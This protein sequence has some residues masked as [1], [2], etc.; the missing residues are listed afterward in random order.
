MNKILNNINKNEEF[1]ILYNVQNKNTIQDFK[2]LNSNISKL[3]KKPFQ[4]NVILDIIYNN[5]RIS[6]NSLKHI[7]EIHKILKNIYSNKEILEKV[8]H[9][10][11]VYIYKKSVI[12]KNYDKESDFKMKLS[13]EDKFNKDE[14]FRYLKENIKKTENIILLFRYKERLS[15]S[16]HENKKYTIKLDMSI[17]K[18]SNIFS[19]LLNQKENFEIELE[20]FSIVNNN[21]I[22]QKKFIKF[23]DF[24]LQILLKN[25]V[26]FKKY[27]ELLQT[28]DFYTM[29][30]ISLDKHIYET[31]IPY[32]Y[33]ITDKA[34]GDKIQLFIHEKKIYLISTNKEITELGKVSVSDNYI[35]EGEKI[36][37]RILLYDILYYKDKDVRKNN[38]KER[39][40]CLDSFLSL[41]NK[42]KNFK[43]DFNDLDKNINDYIQFITKNNNIID[44]KYI[45]L[46]TGLEGKNEVYMYAE[47]IWNA[48]QSMPY[49][50]DGIIF[51]NINQVY[52]KSFKL[53]KDPI[54]KWKPIELN[55]IDFY[56]IFDKNKIVEIEKQNYQMIFLYNY[57]HKGIVPFKKK[58]NLHIGYIKCD[59]DNILK[60]DENKIVKSKTIVEMIYI[61]DNIWKILRTR[62]DKTKKMIMT[63]SKYGNHITVAE[64]IF[65]IIKNPFDLVSSTN[66][67]S[68]IY[69]EKVSS[70]GKEM[71]NFNNHVK[72]YLIKNYCNKK[73]VLDVG[74]GKGGDIHKYF[75][76]KVK[77]IVG[78]EPS[79]YDLF[80]R[81]DSAVN[82]YKKLKETNKDVP[83]M[84]FIQSDFGLPLSVSKQKSIDK[85]NNDNHAN[86]KE[87]LKIT[88]KYNIINFSFSFHYLYTNNYKE[89]LFKNINDKLSKKGLVI[90]TVFDGDKINTFL[91]GKLQK[92]VLYNTNKIFFSIKKISDDEIDLHN[93]IYNEEN[94]YYSEPL[95]FHKKLQTEMK[96]NCNL[97]LVKTQLFEDYLSQEKEQFNN[98]INSKNPEV[99]ASLQLCKLYRYYVFSNNN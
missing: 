29:N 82:R 88:K 96:N 13:K 20:A 61:K 44:K 7:N 79:Q 85:N 40:D 71:R 68:N 46:P 64:N 33:S 34:D 59:N 53:Q 32:Y 14:L 56:I 19:K 67:N 25:K 4:K 45:I 6:V 73:T 81:K 30:P 83:K 60:D 75:Y 49:K 5:Y 37:K 21:T 15:Y 94:S 95:I 27:Q 69:Y 28:N 10:D 92:D 24:I 66:N 16:L 39:L 80:E 51:T 91:D 98:Y 41:I 90:L 62:E 54:Y 99:I 74:I 70:L 47:K 52:E 89:Q 50:L 26:V 42:K 35:V 84:I 18:Q 55:S 9:L 8:L 76:A 43:F 38:L 22:D 58:E 86:I 3:T 57:N 63:N 1:E 77:C 12:I 23:H 2:L 78:V 93:S 72:N 87:Y 17:T 97:D 36:N 65:E 48:F 11:F 31:K